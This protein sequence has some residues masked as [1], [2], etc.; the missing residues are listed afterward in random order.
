MRVG[1]RILRNALASICRIRS[2][3]TRNW[4][5]TSSKVRLYPSTNP[6]RCSN[7]CRSRSVNVSSTSLI[8]SFSNTIAVT[9]LG[10]SA[11]LS[12]IKSPKLVSSLSP[13]GDCKEI[14][15]CAIFKTAR[16]RSTGSKISS[17]T[18]SGEG[19]RPYSCTNCFCTR[20]SLLI[21][22]IMCT[23]IRMVRAWSAMERVMA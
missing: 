13:T 16:T 17:A 11:P 2:R 12:S 3:V 1:C 14:G 8:F 6:K 18:S 21:V 5:P 9:S 19:S 7:T 22:S 23:G 20:I 4:R 15:C 10:F